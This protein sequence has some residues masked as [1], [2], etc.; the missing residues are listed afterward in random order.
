MKSE[1]KIGSRYNSG[2]PHSKNTNVIK[3]L[4]VINTVES[5]K[6]T[7]MERIVR[8]KVPAAIHLG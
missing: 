4:K 3:P 5:D 6:A 2:T 8:N 7:L 1:K